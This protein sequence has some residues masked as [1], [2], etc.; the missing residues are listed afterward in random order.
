MKRRLRSLLRRLI[1]VIY[2]LRVAQLLAEEF[3]S[4]A[5]EAEQSVV[6]RRLRACGSNPTLFLP[7][8]IQQPHNV[9]LGDDVAI[10]PFVHIW[11]GG[12]VRIGSRVMIAS[13]TAITSLTHDHSQANMRETQLSAEVRI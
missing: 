13:H 12:G 10:A 5:Q 11:G 4:A 6:I 9:E 3:S 2:R 8:I 7:L 1:R